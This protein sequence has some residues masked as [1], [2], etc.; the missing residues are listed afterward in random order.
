MGGTTTINETDSGFYDGEMCWGDR[1]IARL[2]NSYLNL[3]R[4]RLSLSSKL[5]QTPL[6]NYLCNRTGEKHE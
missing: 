2:Q 5:L 4:Y 6:N 1:S 3:I